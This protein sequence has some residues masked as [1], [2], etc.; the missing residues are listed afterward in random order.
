MW[1][2]AAMK[3]LLLCLVM[4]L[5][6][7]MPVAVHAQTVR[8]Q[9]ILAL[10]IKIGQLQLLLADMVLQQD[11]SA[12]SYIAVD[13]TTGAIISAKNSA[14]HFPI[15]SITKLMNAVVATENN[16]LVHA[17]ALTSDMLTPQ[18]YSPS[19]FLGAVVAGRDL[20]RASLIQSTNDAA[21]ALAHAAGPEIFIVNMNQKAKDLGMDDTHFEDTHGLS[22][23]NR[24]TA[25][26][27]AKLMAY[28]YQNHPQILATTKDTDFWLPDPTGR[29][30][31]FKNLNVFHQ[32]TDFIGGKTGYL[33]EARQSIASVFNIGGKPVAIIVLY[34]KYRQADVASILEF[35]TKAR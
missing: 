12:G 4:G 25:G 8:A 11:T 18:G 21:E 10:Q 7:C 14:G 27:L 30:L 32:N 19:L 17:I 34:S 20:L 23:Q 31:K 3:K 2:I 24:S 29:L 15:A 33:T 35:V 9:Q 26:D 16:D 1:Y 5:A 28:I 13:L 6:F 22:L